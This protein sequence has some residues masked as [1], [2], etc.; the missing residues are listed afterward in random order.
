M[1]LARVL[2]DLLS[3]LE[4]PLLHLWRGDLVDQLRDATL[5]RWSYDDFADATY[6]FLGPTASSERLSLYDE[7][8]VNV[9]TDDRG[10]VCGL[11]ILDGRAIAKRLEKSG[12]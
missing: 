1:K 10:R 7:L 3:D 11:E 9:D 6:L 12:I 2:P 4:G 8:G 5:E